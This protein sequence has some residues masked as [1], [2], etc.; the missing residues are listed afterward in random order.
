VTRLDWLLWVVLPYVSVTV[1]VVGHIW[2]YRRDQF[3]WTTRS[4]QLLERRRLRIG[5]LLFHFGLLAVLG[6][7]FAG[8]LVPKSLTNA[9]GVPEWTYHDASVTMGTISGTAMVVGFGLLMLRRG[10]DARV[11]ATTSRIDIVTYL[12]LGAVMIMG[13]AET[14]G[15]NLF[16]AGYDYRVT[17]A[18]W[19]RGLFTLQT[20]PS[21]MASAPL[22]YRVHIALAFLLLALWPFSRLVHVWSVPIAYLRRSPIIYR[23]RT[24]QT[25]VARDVEAR[26]T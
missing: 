1:F 13:M 12:L 11:R 2:R 10:T 24:P 7:H 25:H 4:T 6:G 8:I 21:L 19:F 26:E 17:V 14:I 5:N 23:S 22:V 20:D 16:G 9:A 18:P 15:I 3:T